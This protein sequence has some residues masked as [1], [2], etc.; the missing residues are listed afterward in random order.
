MVRINHL[1]F[2]GN[3]TF[4]GTS[5]GEFE[6]HT[7]LLYS[8]IPCNFDSTSHGVVTEEDKGLHKV[9]SRRITFVTAD[10]T[11]AILKISSDGVSAPIVIARQ[12]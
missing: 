7:T 10:V 3:V 4:R 8:V 11:Q 9:R 1:H 12:Q 5:H 2:E 6:T